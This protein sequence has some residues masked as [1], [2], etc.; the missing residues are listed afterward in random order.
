MSDTRVN[1]TEPEARRTA[2]AQVVH[3][4]FNGYDISSGNSYLT[5]Q[6]LQRVRLLHHR[7][8]LSARV[9]RTPS[10]CILETVAGHT[11]G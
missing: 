5:Q 11:P 7:A 10:C 6:P 3:L 4:M 9:A 2:I 8:N 1:R